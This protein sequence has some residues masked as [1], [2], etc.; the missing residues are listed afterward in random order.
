MTN[1]SYIAPF[2]IVTDIKAA[3][4]FYM[5]KLGFETRFIG[6]EDDPFFCHCRP[7]ADLYYAEGCCP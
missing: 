3:V 6:P 2:F 7:R 4:A 1:L 5:D